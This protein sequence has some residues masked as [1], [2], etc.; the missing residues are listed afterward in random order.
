MTEAQIQLQN[1]LTTTFLANMVFL[2]EY[3]NEL[4]QR[5]ENLS[6][7]IETGEYKERYELEFVMENGDFDIFDTATNSY[8]YNKNPKEGNQN[9]LKQVDFSNKNAIVNIEGYFTYKDNK[10]IDINY[11]ANSEFSSLLQKQTQ[12]YSN[13]LNDFLDK[14]LKQYQIIEKYIFFG[15]LLG[16]H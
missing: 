12:E 14:P 7:M 2:S 10:T 5:V 15:T 3:D 9:L 13:A 11:N 6:K 1:A 8:L 4:Y 16:V